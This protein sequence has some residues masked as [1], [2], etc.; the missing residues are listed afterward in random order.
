MVNEVSDPTNDELKVSC[1]CDDAAFD[2]ELERLPREHPVEF[3]ITRRWLERIVKSEA[4]VAEIGVGRHY[5]EI[6]AR[7]RCF[8]QLVD[9]SERLL[10]ATDGNHNSGAAIEPER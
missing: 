4:D 8:L 1:H 9:V 7:K 5:L 10:E 6:L 2:F 3:A